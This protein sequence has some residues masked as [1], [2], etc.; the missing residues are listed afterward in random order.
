[1]R[2]RSNWKEVVEIGTADGILG[3]MLTPRSYRLVGVE[4]DADWAEKAGPYYDTMIHADIQQVDLDI[5][6]GVDCVI[7]GDVLEHLPRPEKTLGGIVAQLSR[8]SVC[9]ISV[10]NVANIWVRLNLLAGRF[11]YAKRGI[12]DETH[13]RF[14][15][16]KTFLRMLANS[17]LIVNEVAYTPIPLNLLHPV[18]AKT[19]P[20]RMIHQ[21]LYTLTRWFPTLF[22]Y[23]MIGRCQ[24]RLEE[25]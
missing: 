12:L 19:G 4:I 21:L 8:D 14:F 20:G 1:M 13:L 7:F 23:Q 9:I 18:F 10:P 25:E 24:K 2:S 15:T 6:R 17:G 5:F 16:R 11:D 22:A 3:R